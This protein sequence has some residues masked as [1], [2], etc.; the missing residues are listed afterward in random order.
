[1]MITKMPLIVSCAASECSYNKRGG[2]HA[3]A[4]TIGENKE[5]VCDTFYKAGHPVGLG[6]GVT[7][8]GACKVE[9]CKHNLNLECTAASGISLASCDGVVYCKTHAAE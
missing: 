5:A 6:E 3:M 4:V 8:V 2:C 1:M 7:F 9:I